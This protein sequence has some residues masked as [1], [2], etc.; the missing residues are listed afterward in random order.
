MISLLLSNVFQL[1]FAEEECI[2]LNNT[3]CTNYEM[4]KVFVFSLY[5]GLRWADVKPLKWE[6]VNEQSIVIEQN[7]TGVSL[8]VPLHD[9]A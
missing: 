8:E 3:P 6:N 4:R 1:F 5:T 7:K 9:A 2:N